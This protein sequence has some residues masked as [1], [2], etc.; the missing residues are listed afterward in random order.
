[1]PLVY[2]YLLLSFDPF[3]RTVCKYKEWGG[4]GRGRGRRMQ[5]SCPQN[6]EVCTKIIQNF[7]DSF[8]SVSPVRLGVQAVFCECH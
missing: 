1:M 5:A 2:W 4:G 6:R 7:T 3:L 8:V